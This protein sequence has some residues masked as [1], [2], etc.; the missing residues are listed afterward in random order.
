MTKNK[1]SIKDNIFYLIKNAWKWDKKAFVYFG[2]FTIVVSIEPFISIFIP[3]F[4][5]DELTGQKRILNLIA[6]LLT[7]FI[8]SCIVNYMSTYLEGAYFPRMIG[9]RFNFTHKLQKKCMTMDFKYTEDPKVLNDIQTAY[10]AVQNNQEGIEG[11]LHKLF[12]LFGESI[13]FFGYVAIVFTLNPLILLY[14]LLNVIFIYY[15]TT[16]AKKYEYSRADQVSE[17]ERKSYYIYDVMSNFAYGKDIRIFNLS[18]WLQNK[19]RVFQNSSLKIQKDIKYKYFGVSV[20][21]VF[22]LLLREGVVYAYLIY[23]VLNGALSIGS[24]TMYFTTI[25]GFAG[26][27]QKVLDDIAHINAQ[28]LY[29]NNFRNLLEFDNEKEKKQFRSIPKADTYEIEFKNVSFKYPNSEKYI[30]KNLSLKV[31]KGQRLALVG[32]NGAGKTTFVKLITRL[33][34]PT[35]GEILLNG[36]NILEFNKEEYYKLFSVEFQEIKMLA[37]SIAENVALIAKSKIDKNMVNQCIEK[38]GL[39]EKIDSLEN[40][41]DTLLLKVLDSKGIELSGGENQKLALARALYK[42]GSIVILDEPTSALDPLAE[43]NLY[44]GFNDMIGDKTAIY[45]SHRLSSTRFCDVIAFLEN[46]EI[47]EYGT[48]EELLNQGGAYSEM[49][50]IQ[51]SYYKEKSLEMEEA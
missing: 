36:I 18:N 28:N 1:R 47:K 33:Y 42:N 7:F 9:I 12:A 50:S 31:K 26:W 19:L 37:F 39:K 48:H 25:A 29:I 23:M 43:Y 17:I 3:K 27:M 40:G 49:F 38:S 22:L 30:Y 44:K 14:L 4:L 51:A 45:I 2:L 41:I 46:G 11:V 20:L 10:R 5:I 13:A 32:V 21:D 24:F 8:I 35:E 15:L 16:R 6:M 34:E